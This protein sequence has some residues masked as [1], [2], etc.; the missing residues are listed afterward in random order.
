MSDA[1]RPAAGPSPATGRPLIT[2]LYVPGDRPDRFEKAVATGADLVI[3]DLED[4]VAGDNKQLARDEVVRW[5]SAREVSARSPVVQVRINPLHAD[6]TATAE[7]TS[8]V[9]AADLAA[10]A[11]VS[12][13]F[14][15]RVPKVESA[16]DVDLVVDAAP[17]H[18]VTA[19][20]ETALGVENA[21][22][23]AR[24]PSVTRLALGESDLASDLGTSAPEAMDYARVRVLFAARAAGLGAPM[25]SAFTGIRDLDGLHADTERGRALGWVGRTA[26]HP[27]QLSVIVEVFRPNTAEEAWAREVLAATATGG[28]ATL[29]S[30]EMVDAAMVGRARG[31]LALAQGTTLE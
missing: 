3:L 30:G 8:A 16:D 27:S 9:G 10:L 29:A 2:G 14:E 6:S 17:G 26:V 20:L 19:L 24:H 5:L 12:A 4:A 15:L 1:R 22:A 11:R 25:L 13:N 18:P 21:A 7:S 28:V 23:I 31:I